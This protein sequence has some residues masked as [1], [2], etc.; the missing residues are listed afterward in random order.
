MRAAGIAWCVD[1]P[2]LQVYLFRRTYPD[3][4]KNHMEGPSGFPILLSEFT[5]TGYAKI[6]HSDGKISFW[7]GSSIFLC[8][9]QHE[10]NIYDFQGAEIHVLMID[11]LTQWLKNMYTYLRG[12]VRMV[13][14]ELPEKYK[15]LFPRVL[16]GANPGGLGHNWVKSAWIDLGSGTHQMPKQDGGMLREYIRA[17]L[18]D[19]PVGVAA[20]PNYEDR[21]SGLGD[22]ALVKAMRDGDWD[23][24]AG[25]A[26]DDVWKREVHV[27]KPFKIP[28]GWSVDRSFDW[29][30]S[31]P[32]AALWWA[33][34][35]G[36]PAIMADGSQ[37]SFPAGT[38][39]LIHE[40]Y[41]WNG[42]PN[43]GCRKLNAEIAREILRH[44]EGLKL[45]G[46]HAVAPGPADSSI[47]DIVD[48]KRM[49]DEFIRCGVN[50]IESD[51][52]PGSRIAGLQKLRDML[53]A[54]L[55]PHMEEPGLFVFDTCTHFIRTVPVLQRDQKKPDDVD[56]S[57]EDHIYDATR[58]RLFARRYVSGG[59]K[60]WK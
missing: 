53:S 14:I 45:Q 2:G 49:V 16:C 43:E 17:K 32:F 12:R 11:E 37:R 6:N 27:L 48:G 24:V 57:A 46:I 52:S 56:S 25:G 54:S 31:K 34:S 39:F 55:Q 15:G 59:K 36:T 22:E 29:G 44:E 3:L 35:D 50:W 58:Y 38:I 28:A 1:I 19:N 10:K 33:E 21:L 23:I 26:I 9:C 5:Q 18:E 40:Y 60:N 13:G 41:G 7:N 30:S 42:N 8:H 4:W 20:D 47:F 51:K